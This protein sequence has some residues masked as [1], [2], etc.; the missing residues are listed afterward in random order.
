M[1]KE[2]FARAAGLVITTSIATTAIASSSWSSEFKFISIS[3]TIILGAVLAA[4]AAE[5]EKNT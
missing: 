1:K 2:N 4:L 3:A 5:V